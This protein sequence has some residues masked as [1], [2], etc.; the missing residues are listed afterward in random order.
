LW[1]SEQLNDVQLVL[2]HLKELDGHGIDLLLQNVHLAI[3]LGRLVKEGLCALINRND[4]RTLETAIDV[5][6]GLIDS[7]DNLSDGFPNSTD[8]RTLA[9][10]DGRMELGKKY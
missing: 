1:H 9:S 8:R 5:G 10:S 3:G 6:H 2:L 4:F 7:A